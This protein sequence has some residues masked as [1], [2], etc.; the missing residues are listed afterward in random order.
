MF[1]NI[2]YQLY[3]HIEKNSKLLKVLSNFIWRYIET[4]IVYKSDNTP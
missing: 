3:M 2:F 4:F 1:V